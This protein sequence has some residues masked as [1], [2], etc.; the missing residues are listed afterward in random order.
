MQKKYVTEKKTLN[1]INTETFNFQ[2]C[3]AMDVGLDI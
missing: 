3:V 2:S 1:Q